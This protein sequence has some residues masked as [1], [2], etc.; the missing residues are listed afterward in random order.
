MNNNYFKKYFSKLHKCI[1]N[2]ENIKLIKQSALNLK[3]LGRNKIIIFGNGGSA[4]IA[5]HFTTD[6][7]KNTNLKCLNLSDT[8]LITCLANDYGYK[9]VNSKFLELYG[10]KGDILIAIS[11]SGKSLNIINSVKTAKK[12]GFSKI[13]TLSGFKKNNKLKQCGDFNFWIDSSNYNII[14]NSH[15]VLLL[16]LIDYIS[17]KK[18]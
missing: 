8:S 18:Y 3:S 11:S 9:N 13:I 14:E 17:N 15:Q 16:T 12:I 7:L 6:V 4:A 5:S 1:S 10:N 2:K